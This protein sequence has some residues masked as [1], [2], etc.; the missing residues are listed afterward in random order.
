MTP[1]GYC[2]PYKWESKIAYLKDENLKYLMGNQ[3]LYDF[4]QKDKAEPIGHDDFDFFDEHLASIQET[5][6]KVLVT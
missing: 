2:P 3:A 4:M 6:Y 1:T 5:D